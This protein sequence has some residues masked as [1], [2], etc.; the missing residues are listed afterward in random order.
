MKKITSLMLIIFLSLFAYTSRLAQTTVLAKSDDNIRICHATGSN[1]NPYNSITVDSDSIDGLG[2]GNAD[3]NQDGHQNGQDIIPPGYW[4]LDGRNWTPENQV[5]W[6]NDCGAVTS[7]PTATPT[8]TQN[9]PSPTP[10][11]AQ[12]NPTAT[13][14]PYI[15]ECDNECECDCNNEPTP[16][17]VVPTIIL[18]TIPTDCPEWANN[19]SIGNIFLTPT[20]APSATPTVTPD[21]TATPAP[22]SAPSNNS[23]TGGSSSSSSSNSGSSSSSSDGHVL[24]AATLPATGT[25]MN[26][27]MDALLIA[28]LALIVLTQFA[29]APKRS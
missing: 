1:T 16:T 24:G 12:V 4:D 17:S 6:A 26:N 25:F 22:T 29:Y 7:T 15:V 20:A 18:P 10:T 5:I 27:L 2:N 9:N 21:P 23:G 13:P 19:C 28:G 14:T 3:H 11:T 8:V